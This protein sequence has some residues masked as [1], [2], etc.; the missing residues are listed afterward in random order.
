MQSAADF[1]FLSKTYS[2]EGVPFLLLLLQVLYHVKDGFDFDGDCLGKASIVLLLEALVELAEDELCQ[3]PHEFH[4]ILVFQAF[5][6][7]NLQLLSLVNGINYGLQE[8]V[9][10]QDCGLA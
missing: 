6:K 7:D 2:A 4:V 1:S 8:Q 9:K 5:D 10:E 3:T